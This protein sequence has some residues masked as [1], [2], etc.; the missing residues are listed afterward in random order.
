MVDTKY[1]PIPKKDQSDV[2]EGALPV[3]RLSSVPVQHTHAASLHLSRQ[4]PLWTFMSDSSVGLLSSNVLPL[5]SDGH[6]Q[7]AGALDGSCHLPH[8]TLLSRKNQKATMHY[9]QQSHYSR[10]TSVQIQVH[11]P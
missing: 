5:L 11:S 7:A 8:L 4:W 1:P 9:D 6:P 3:R 2:V 10:T